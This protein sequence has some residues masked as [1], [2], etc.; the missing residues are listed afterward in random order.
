M[1]LFKQNNEACTLEI[2]IVSTHKEEKS[3]QPRRFQTTVWST[4]PTFHQQVFK[5]KLTFFARTR[6][7]ANI[8]CVCVCVLASF[9][10]R[11]LNKVFSEKFV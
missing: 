9:W 6:K 5:A 8:V 10:P 7:G 1:T 11:I 4:I 3:F 2:R